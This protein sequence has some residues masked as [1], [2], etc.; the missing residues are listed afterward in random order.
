MN[1]NSLQLT[2]FQRDGFLVV[3]GF[4]PAATCDALIA[5]AKAIVDEFLP[6]NEQEVSVFTTNDQVRRS[7]AYFLESG[8]KVRCFF[9]EE[10]LDPETGALKVD[11]SI[12]INKIGHAL[13]ALE[14]AFEEFSKSAPINQ[15]VNALGMQKPALVQSMYIFKNPHIGGDVSCHQDS[16]FLHTDPLSVTGL[17]FALEDATIENGCMWALPGGHKGPL[18][19]RFARNPEGTG[20]VMHELDATPFPTPSPT[21]PWVPLEAK[22][23]TLVLL[24]GLLPHWS[25]S[26]RSPNSRHAYALHYVDDACQ[27]S[28]DNWML[29]ADS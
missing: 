4:V 14:P 16:T 1:P 23:G 8:D 27:W 12:S 7:D 9:E 24:H 21:A 6:T 25:S 5:R 17:W 11:K 3:P 15:M 18:R 26:N 2:D 10:A 28:R 20:T 13:H 22:K 19:R 29:R